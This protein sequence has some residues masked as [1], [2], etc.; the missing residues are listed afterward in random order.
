M[1]LRR[2]MKNMFVTSDECLRAEGNISSAFVK[3]Q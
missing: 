2:A 1:Q 3:C